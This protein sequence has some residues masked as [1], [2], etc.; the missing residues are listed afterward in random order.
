MPPCLLDCSSI[1]LLCWQF[2]RAV[3]VDELGLSDRLRGG[4]SPTSAPV[5]GAPAAPFTESTRPA[6]GAWNAV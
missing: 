2:C 3:T 1:A 4:T 5:A 6:G